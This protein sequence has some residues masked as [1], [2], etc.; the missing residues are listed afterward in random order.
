MLIR[1]EVID[2]IG[3]LDQ[4]FFFYGED[5]EF[6]HRV[7][8]AGWKVRYDPGAS[9]IH[10]GGASSDPT[11]VPSRA[12]NELMWQAR[13]LLQRLCYGRLSEWFIRG[14][15]ITSFGLRY[16]KLLLRGRTKTPEFATQRDVLAILLKAPRANIAT[17]NLI[18]QKG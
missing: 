17:P 8:Q 11:R 10:L 5:A 6:C 3:P 16:L 12:R 7:W 14:V 13:Y 4:R 9:I 18:G 1:R 2:R 15:D